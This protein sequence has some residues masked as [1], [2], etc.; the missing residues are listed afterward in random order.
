M[1][2]V[3][4]RIYSLLALSMV[5]GGHALATSA[6]G[7]QVSAT[8]AGVSINGVGTSFSQAP[9]MKDGSLLVPMR[10][11]F[12]QLG[13]KVD[14]HADTQS[15]SAEKGKTYIDLQVGSTQAT[16]NGLSLSLPVAPEIINGSTMVPIR[17]V[18]ESLGAQVNWDQ[19]RKMVFIESASSSKQPRETKPAQQ[20]ATNPQASPSPASGG[21]DVAIKVMYNGQECSLPVSPAKKD[22]ELMLPLDAFFSQVEYSN[23]MGNLIA[24][25][26]NPDGY[27]H[28]T[29][30]ITPDG[31]IV[32]LDNGRGISNSFQTNI[33]PLAVDGKFLVDATTLGIILQSDLSWNQDQTALTF[34]SQNGGAI[35]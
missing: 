18:S 32:D 5:A 27:L 11:I 16:K 8:S 1:K 15:I 9:V 3:R 4:Q 26:G 28:I 23:T 17:F 24:K 29:V 2:F 30:T 34:T 20:T 22:R 14:Y 35:K 33:K 31:G 13:A 19:S 21:Q 6:G 25:T 12:E 7:G 10:G